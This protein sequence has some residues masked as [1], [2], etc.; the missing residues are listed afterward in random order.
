M[1]MSS[2]VKALID[3]I[4][5][6]PTTSSFLQRLNQI[7]QEAPD[8]LSRLS[9]LLKIGTPYEAKI[10]KIV[11]SPF[12]GL[13][14]T[15]SRLDQASIYIG[16]MGLYQLTLLCEIFQIFGSRSHSD[17][18]REGF[19]RHS[20]ACGCA[21][22]EIARHM[23]YPRLM[24]AFVGGVLHDIGKLVWDQFLTKD[25]KKILSRVREKDQWILVTE[26]ELFNVSHAELGAWLLRH[27]SVHPLWDRAVR[28]HHE[29]FPSANDDPLVAIVHVADVM[30]RALAVGD[31]GD[32]SIPQW[33]EQALQMCQ[34]TPAH[35]ER[36]LGRVQ[37]SLPQ[38]EPFLSVALS[39]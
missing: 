27:W 36:V 19:W 31:P 2:D 5:N 12:Y 16:S 26:Q 18:S 25:F 4:K 37:R 20:F 3:T 34:L 7:V 1:D 22:L 35:L 21:S 15:V 33:N 14:Q 17:Y 6:P 29:P 30:A 8:D 32:E 39:V 9:G 23:G 13:H 11:N 28:Y 38:V 10:L 24:D